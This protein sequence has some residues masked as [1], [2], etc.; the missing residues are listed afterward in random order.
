MSQ[1][2]ET[3]DNVSDVG[4]TSSE[5]ATENK[6][7]LSSFTIFDAMLLIWLLCIM[8]ATFLMF[9]EL[10]LFGDFPGGFPWRTDEAAV[11]PISG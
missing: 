7:L 2:I 5:A 3:P 9:R 1:A 10:N 11:S 6:G 8:V 4:Q